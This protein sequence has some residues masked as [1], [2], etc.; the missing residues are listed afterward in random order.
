MQVLR[1]AMAGNK[2]ARCGNSSDAEMEAREIKFESGSHDYDGQVEVRLCG[3]CKDAGMSGCF[4]AV[5]IF[6]LVEPATPVELLTSG[7]DQLAA[8]HLEAHLK[9]MT[10]IRGGKRDG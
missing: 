1:W 2:C 9:R 5:S 3:E 8:A 10:E 4:V 7:I 6:E